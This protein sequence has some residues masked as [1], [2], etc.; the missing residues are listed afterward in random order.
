MNPL[1]SSVLE[2]AT[3]PILLVACDFDGTLA[4][5]VEDPAAARPDA[6]AVE[7]L[8]RLSALPQTHVAVISGRALA[9]LQKLM[10]DVDGIELIGSHGSESSLAFASGLPEA[11]VSLLDELQ[12]QVEQIASRFPGMLIERKPASIAAHYR[13]VDASHRDEVQSALLGGPARLEGVFVRPGKC[14][15][16]LAVVEM[17][18][19]RALQS[20]RYR[21][22]A[23]ASIFIGDDQTDEEAFAVMAAPDVSIKVGDGATLASLNVD[24]VGAVRELLKNLALTRERFLAQ[25]LVAPIEQHSILSDQRTAALVNPQG[26][27]VWLCLP[28]IDGSP[29]FAELLGGPYAGY[30]AVAPVS[31][32]GP[33][34]QTYVDHSFVLETRW[35]DM[36]VTDY[37]DCTAGRAYQRA[38]RTDL[39]RVI[40]GKGRAVVTFAPKIDFGRMPTRLIPVDGGLEVDG[41]LDPIVLYSP[42]VEWRI[43]EDGPHQYAAAEIELGDEPVILEL[44]YGTGNLEPRRNPEVIRREE[45]TQFWSTWA[46]T[47]VLPSVR[48]ELVK[49]S[50][51]ALRSLFHGPTGAIAAAATTSLPEHLGGIRNWDYRY[52]W[53][54]DAAL[55]ASALVRLGTT[56]QAMKFLDWLLGVL[57]RCP[58][59]ESLAPVYTVAGGHL[60]PEAEIGSLTGYRGSRPVRIGNLA[61]QQVQ[62]DVFGPITELVALLAGHGAALSS[63]HW[64]LVEIMVSAV[65]HR[66]REPDHGIWEIRLARRHHVHSKT[67]CW[68]TVDCALAVAKYLGRKRPH[69]ADLRDSIAQDV[70][71]HGWKEHLGAFSGTY[72]NEH[73]D[74]TALALGLSGLI[75]PTDERFVRTVEAI[76]KELRVGPTVYRYRCDDGIAGIEGGFN[77]C[78]AWL[79][80]AY[81]AIGRRDAAEELFEQYCALAG[82]TGL[83]SE[84]FDPVEKVALG[85]FP[86]AYSHLGLINAAVRLSES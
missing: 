6:E 10:G 82:P 84:E 46:Q 11:A 68:M 36:T 41:F 51:L 39:I 22:A 66:W 25:S 85:N 20:I 77:L 72:E 48:P 17:S 4:H 81:A 70:L 31:G 5:I 80:E 13:S 73:L 71:Q 12:K 55:S 23:T 56:G 3:A 54:R 67:M 16:E 33:V 58:S 15:I 42:G 19:G 43:V 57:E 79:I 63:E 65:E 44:R 59:P 29:L 1:H 2:I 49:R 7:A 60:M 47:L 83:M 30:F 53:P 74:A 38:G 9:D 18:K 61:S 86:Q 14:V 28:R 50:A 37:L 32:D 69:W 78:T 64:R 21:H 75:A 45:T 34:G 76:E 40:R 24:D 35:K 62:L 26:R 8:K 52:C 27:V